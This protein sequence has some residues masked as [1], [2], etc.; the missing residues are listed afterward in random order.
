M[1]IKG[2]F[3]R[4]TNIMVEVFDLQGRLKERVRFK[5][6]ITTV[7]LNLIRNALAGTLATITD[8][9]VRYIAVGDDNTAPAL[10]D[11]VLGNEVFR[12]ARTS[13]TVG[14][15]LLTTIWYIAPAEAVGAIEEMGWFCGP[16]ATAA[17]DSGSML[18]RVLYSRVKTNL[19]S[20]K[21][22]RTDTI[23]EG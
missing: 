21:V 16:T 3:K 18:S 6:L 7:G 19:E 11:T 1:L 5:N 9:E 17:A 10:T 12:K 8:A 22:T 23:Q 13:Y 2:E 4:V 14:A 15:G 20:I